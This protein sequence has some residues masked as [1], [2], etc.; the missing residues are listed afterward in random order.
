MTPALEKR[1]HRKQ[2]PEGTGEGS[3]LTV[4]TNPTLGSERGESR[5]WG[6]FSEFRVA[7]RDAAPARPRFTFWE[8]ERQK[9][10]AEAK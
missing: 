5:R 7:L 4:R 6:K 2:S 10:G 9:G 8:E 1:A 3:P